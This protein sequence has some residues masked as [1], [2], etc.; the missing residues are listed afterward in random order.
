MKIRSLNRSRLYAWE[1]MLG[2]TGGVLTIALSTPLL[3]PGWRALVMH[4]FAPVCH[5][6]PERSPHLE[7]VQLALCDRC[8]G[9]YVGCVLGVA[10][11]NGGRRFWR[12]IRSLDQYVLLGSLAPLA[13][14]WI[15]PLLGL[16]TNV[17]L[18]RAVTGLLFGGVAASF[19]ADRILQGLSPRACSQ[20]D[21]VCTI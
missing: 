15:G 3:A 16:W 6:L 21:E 12:R 7:G 5:Q 20:S 2:A 13:I 17:P 1:I 11:I 9:I 8:V 19:A 18:S 10:A 4:V 14:D